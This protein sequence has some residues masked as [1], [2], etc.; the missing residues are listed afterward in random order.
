MERTVQPVELR[1][2]FRENIVRRRKELALTQAALAIRLGVAQP[3]VAQIESGVR[4]PAIDTIARFANA[5]Q[6]TPDALL[7]PEIFSEVALTA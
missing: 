6:T 4:T 2:V 7:T 3:W 1:R 5:L